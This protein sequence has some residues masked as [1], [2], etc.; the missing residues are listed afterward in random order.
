LLHISAGNE[1]TLNS[2]HEVVSA[3]EYE[4][5]EDVNLIWGLRIDDSIG[6]RVKV[7]M[8]VASIPESELEI[9]D[10]KESLSSLGESVKM[11]N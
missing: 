9:E 10:V 11:I 6:S 5:S 1:L 3:L 4:L 2:C 8:L 7:V